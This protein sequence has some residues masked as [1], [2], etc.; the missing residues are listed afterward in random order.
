M[1][2]FEQYISENRLRIDTG[3]LGK[4][5][6]DKIASTFRRLDSQ[7]RKRHFFAAAIVMLFIALGTLLYLAF[8]KQTSSMERTAILDGV[9][10]YYKE[11][12]IS[13][14]KL[15]DG[16][17]EA[18]RQQSIP[19]EYKDMFTDFLKQLQIID[20]QYDIYKTEISEHGYSQ[21]IIQQVIYNYQMKL[22][23]LQMLQSEIIKIN[24]RTKNME[25][26]NRKIQLHI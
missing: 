24:S 22:S 16:E 23:V 8:P 13:S 21:E 10:T 14:I 26:E 11:A 7:K 18:I 4:E 5:E 17:E 25:N 19:V 6:W 15:I 20:K 3:E 12:E 2:K 9:A 1:D